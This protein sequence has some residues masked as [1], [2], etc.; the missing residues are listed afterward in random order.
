M[1]YLKGFSEIFQHSSAAAQQAIGYVLLV[2]RRGG[3]EEEEED[4]SLPSG[5]AL[6]CTR[7][8][9]GQEQR[10]AKEGIQE[11]IFSFYSS[12]KLK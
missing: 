6:H 10:G 9:T 1:K 8:R 4:P 5:D 7:D 11:R 3:G 12:K 2:D